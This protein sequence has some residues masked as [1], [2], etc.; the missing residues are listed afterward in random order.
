[1]PTNQLRNV[2]LLACCQAIFIGGQTTI[3]FIGGLIGYELAPDKAFATLPVTTVILGTACMTIPASLFMGR[4]GRRTGF[5]TGAVI[6]AIGAIVCSIAI[7]AASFPMFCFGTFLI[8]FYNAFCQYYRFAVADA[9]PKDKSARYVS[10][11]L[12]GG[13][14]AAFL[15]PQL[16]LWTRD[17]IPQQTYLGSY[18]TI[19]GLIMFAMGLI[20]FL[21]IP[22]LTAEEKA[23]ESRPILEIM[24][25]KRF[26]AAAGCGIIAYAVMSLLMTATPLAMLSCNFIDA[27]AGLV[28]QWHVIGMFGP[29]F[30]TGDLINRFGLYRVM[31]IGVVLMMAAPLLDLQG[32]AFGNFLGALLLVGLGW[33]FVFIGATTLLT[34]V[35]NP[36]ERAKTQAANDFLVFGATAMASFLSGALL[37]SF[38]WQVV[39]FVALPLVA[40]AG[41]LILWAMMSERKENAL[42]N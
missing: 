38:G 18:L 32:I 2:L 35:H 22:S 1:M 27:D 15:G 5:L 9:A 10:W 33:N 7:S 17:L 6:G 29:S 13:V 36:A 19:L 42:A 8:G 37:H 25:S 26:I 21:R 11:V 40:V 3:F 12:A 34:R 28:I 39:N 16:A 23:A 20:S 4:F 14:V 30:F 41:A 31:F 24:L